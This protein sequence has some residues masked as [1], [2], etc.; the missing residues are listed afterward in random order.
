MDPYDLYS[1]FGRFWGS[2][3]TVITLNVLALAGL[4]YVV[5]VRLEPLARFKRYL[6]T[7]EGKRAKEVFEEFGLWSKL[8]YIATV[9][10]LF[11]L[12]VFNSLSGLIG[13][14]ATTDLVRNSSNPVEFYDVRA[15][16]GDLGAIAAYALVDPRLA[17]VVTQSSNDGAP[18]LIG[19][20]NVESR[21]AADYRARSVERF[22]E[23]VGWAWRRSGDAWFLFYQTILLTAVLIGVGIAY[24]VRRARARRAPSIVRS[25]RYLVMIAVIALL[26]LPALRWRAEDKHLLA[27]DNQRL[28]VV[29]QLELD[30]NRKQPSPEAIEAQSERIR[31]VLERCDVPDHEVP[32]WLE[33]DA[34]GTFYGRVWRRFAIA[35]RP[36]DTNLVANDSVIDANDEREPPPRCE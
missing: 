5:G 17:R 25:L 26:A 10:V 22:D 24:L 19:I 20:W 18:S 29:R 31:Q 36:Y 4:R 16:S 8:P 21:L 23:D 15:Y 11:Y 27:V 14:I 6:D 13:Q 12:I 7:T 9:A 3:S 1:S 33:R 35:E 2:V 30:P 32:F 28:V 34:A